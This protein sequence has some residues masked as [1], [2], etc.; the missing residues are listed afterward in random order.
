MNVA[1]HRDTLLNMLNPLEFQIVMLIHQVKVY[2]NEDIHQ[3]NVWIKQL[4][5]GLMHEQLLMIKHKQMESLYH[6]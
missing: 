1:F 2:H 4:N 6:Q 3:S 5:D